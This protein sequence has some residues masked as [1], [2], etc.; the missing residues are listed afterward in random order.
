MTLKVTRQLQQLVD[1]TLIFTPPKT[2]AGVRTIALPAFLGTELEGHFASWAAA[3]TDG[4]LFIGEKG[5][6]LRRHVLHKHWRLATGSVG[7]QDL[8]FHDLRH[9]GNTLAAATGASTK[10][11]MSRMGHASPQAAL[12]Y[13]HATADRDAAIAAGLHDR[14]TGARS[15][16][17]EKY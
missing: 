13:Q 15:A 11:L 3:G 16:S 10:G 9:V 12:R 8:H 5:G 17:I 14:V 7:R 2:A 4:L 1:G 6:P